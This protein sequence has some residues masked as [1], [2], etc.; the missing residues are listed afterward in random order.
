MHKNDHKIGVFLLILKILT[1]VFAG[2]ILKQKLVLFR[3]QLNRFLMWDSC[4][5]F[6]FSWLNS[7]TITERNK[8]QWIYQWICNM[9]IIWKLSYLILLRI[10]VFELF[11][12]WTMLIVFFFLVFII[13]IWP[14]I[15]PNNLRKFYSR[16][17]EKHGWTSIFVVR[18]L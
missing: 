6:E 10:I 11:E 13:S 5:D 7:I 16:I 9:K 8:N 3:V 14:A 1:L 4:W 2:N 12:H 18:V 15:K 17:F